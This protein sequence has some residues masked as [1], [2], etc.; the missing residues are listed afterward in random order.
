MNTYGKQ[1]K[2]TPKFKHVR[3]IEVLDGPLISEFTE[4]DGEDRYL[5]IWRDS[6]EDYNRWLAV[7]CSLREIAMYEAQ[8]TTLAWMVKRPVTTYLVDSD[9][10]GKFVQWHSLNRGDFP[11]EYLP[12][13]RSYYDPKL[14][15]RSK[16]DRQ[17]QILIDG[18]WSLE[19]IAQSARRFRGGL[20]RAVAAL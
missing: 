9:E 2:G 15:P 11:D 4:G 19:E 12:A 6:D 8:K 3:D 7:P 20:R 14:R 1:I 10:T 5:F 18:H 16:Q 13:D 17:Q